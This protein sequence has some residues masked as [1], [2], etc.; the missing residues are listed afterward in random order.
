MFTYYTRKQITRPNSLITR[1][2][3]FTL[4]TSADGVRR[5]EGRYD[6]SRPYLQSWHPFLT[7]DAASRV[8]QVCIRTTGKRHTLYRPRA[9]YGPPGRCNNHATGVGEGTE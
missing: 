7:K 6:R 4:I 2:Y 1:H 5:S 3:C 8:A 9:I